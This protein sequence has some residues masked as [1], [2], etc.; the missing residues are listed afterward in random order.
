MLCRRTPDPGNS[1]LVPV[2]TGRV[3]FARLHHPHQLQKIQGSYLFYTIIINSLTLLYINVKL[4]V[5][6]AMFRPTVV[7]LNDM[8]YHN[9]LYR[10]N[11]LVH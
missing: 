10:P 6:I 11:F 1:R 7:V 5:S 2:C 8:P 4:T 9:P 3:H